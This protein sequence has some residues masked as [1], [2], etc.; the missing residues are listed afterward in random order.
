MYEFLNDYLPRKWVS[1]AD[2][3][4]LIM[5]QNMTFVPKS[6]GSLRPCLDPRQ[7]NSMILFD[8]EPIV[9]VEQMLRNLDPNAKVFVVIDLAKGYNAIKCTEEA[10]KYLGFYGPK[11]GVFTFN[12]MPFGVWTAGAVYSRAV[13]ILLGPVRM[14]F[15]ADDG[16]AGAA[17]YRK[18][19]E[20][21]TAGF[22]AG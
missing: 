9:S 2:P 1:R 7:L 20:M 18:L 21:Q 5:I 3:R 13:S 4:D 8:P 6:D 11:N 17:N 15:F 22:V 14:S 12:V 10:R 16:I 19:V